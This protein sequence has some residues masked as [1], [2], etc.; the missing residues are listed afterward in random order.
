MYDV[1]Y[2]TFTANDDKMSRIE[3]TVS[4]KEVSFT[5]TQA[6]LVLP[7]KILSCIKSAL[8]SVR[9]TGL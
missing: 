1:I 5:P 2:L 4:F 6:S 7:V 8:L 9:C 3:A